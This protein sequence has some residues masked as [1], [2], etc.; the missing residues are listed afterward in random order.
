MNPTILGVKVTYST[1]RKGSRLRVQGL[2]P[3]EAQGSA[4][5]SFPETYN[6]RDLRTHIGFL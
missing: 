1:T 2:G 3:V 5:F 6:S 4:K